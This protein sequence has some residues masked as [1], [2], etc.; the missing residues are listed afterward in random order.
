LAALVTG[1]IWICVGTPCTAPALS[2]SPADDWLPI[3][4]EERA[5][6]KDPGGSGA[7]AI[8]LYRAVQ[9]NDVSSTE[10]HYYRI[11][12]FTEEGKKYGDVEIRYLKGITKI[13]DLQARTIRPDGSILEFKADVFDKVQTKDRSYRVHRKTFSFPEVAVGAILEYRFKVRWDPYLSLAPDWIVQSSLPTRRVAFTFIPSPYATLAWVYRL[14]E[15][16]APRTGGRNKRIELTME[17][18]PP[19]VEE[20][21][22]PPESSLK[23]S[24]S[25][26]YFL[27]SPGS[28]DQFWKD[29]GKAW[30]ENIEGFIGKREAIRQAAGQ[31]VA[32]ED[33]PETKLR[34]LYASV[35][36][37]RNLSYQP[38]RTGP[39]AGREKFKKNDNAEDVLRNGYGYPR[40]INRLFVALA[41]AAGFEAWAVPVSERAV[42]LFDKNLLD[43]RQLD[44]EVAVVKIGE[45][46][47]YLDAGMPHCPFGLLS[48]VRTDVPGIR[49]GKEGGAFVRTPA[50]RSEQAVIER[51]GTLVLTDEGTLQGTVAVTFTGL[52]AVTRRLSAM[53]TD[54]VGRRRELEEEIQS[55]LPTNAKVRLGE[56]TGWEG[57]EPPLR[58]QV[59][60]TI[61]GYAQAT[62]RRTLLPIGVFQ[63]NETHPFRHA[64]RVHAVYLR[65]PYQEIDDLT[66]KLPAGLQVETIPE[67]RQSN[68]AWG[69]YQ[70]SRGKASQG[71][72]LRRALSLEGYHFRVENYE[73][74]RSF[75]SQVRAGDEEQIVL[76]RASTQPE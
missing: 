70:A 20:D 19:F 59:E 31:L 3:S 33:S 42:R 53:Q 2:A 15:G 36:Q 40:E 64:R 13:D 12:V 44:G 50:P 7:H 32:A 46:E 73:Q 61:E 68:S 76:Q 29:V 52:E 16:T 4:P 23:Y 43:V 38:E 8:L 6:T 14:P 35:Q 39:G 28:P 65:N 63:W 67:P 9:T 49:P 45:K 41:R 57:F 62:G 24:V 25:F 75:F 71:I 18:V 37:V 54:D 34:K 10:S 30:H 22:I 69:R 47:L 66:I 58:A 27:R 55:W 21:F 17:N 74:L 1:L 48:W 72:R 51:Q 5:M 56:V 26:Y 11:K 60:L